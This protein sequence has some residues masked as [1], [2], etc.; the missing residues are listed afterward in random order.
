MLKPSTLHG[1]KQT[2]QGAWVS[3]AMDVMRLKHIETSNAWE[4]AVDP[5]LKSN[6][7]VYRSNSFRFR[8]LNY[9]ANEVKEV[10]LI[11][12]FQTPEL[13]YGCKE[14][15]TEWGLN[16]IEIKKSAFPH[17]R[18]EDSTSSHIS[19]NSSQLGRPRECM[20][21]AVET[22]V[23][24]SL[25]NHPT[26]EGI[27]SDLK[28]YEMV[29]YNLLYRFFN[30]HQYHPPSNNFEVTVHISP[31]RPLNLCFVFVQCCGG[32]IFC[33]ITLLSILLDTLATMC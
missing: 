32:A 15:R 33:A 13:P 4:S 20:G 3:N 8:P 25:L 31:S 21:G 7:D 10:L 19:A 5:L 16:S 30:V 23:L 27:C 6:P 28:W 2:L 14:R 1:S 18:N 9:E 17:S 24:S 22:S 12:R 11:L 29:L 26:S